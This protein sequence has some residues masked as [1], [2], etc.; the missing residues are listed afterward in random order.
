[1]CTRSKL[2]NVF[3]YLLAYAPGFKNIPFS[4]WCMLKMDPNIF[5]CKTF[6]KMSLKTYGHPPRKVVYSDGSEKKNIKRFHF[7]L[8]FSELVAVIVCMFRQ[9]LL[10]TFLTQS[11]KSTFSL[12]VGSESQSIMMLVGKWTALLAILLVCCHHPVNGRG[13][14]S[15][16]C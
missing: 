9:I 10:E 5:G 7:L 16:S 15:P 8:F 2:Q 12:K 3:F 14:L 6:S 1:M 11:S 4:N 13:N